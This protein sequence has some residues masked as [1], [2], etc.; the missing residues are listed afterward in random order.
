MINMNCILHGIYRK[1]ILTFA[2]TELKV[3]LIASHVPSERKKLQ[4]VTL[5]I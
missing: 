3:T 2:F 1:I 5:I 4:L